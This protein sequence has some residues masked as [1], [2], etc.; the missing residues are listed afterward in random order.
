MAAARV[1][2]A[3]GYDPHLSAREMADSMRRADELGFEVGFFSET[4]EL[5]RD[6]VSTLAAMALSTERMT[7]GCTQIVRL[8][9]P[10]VMA[11]TA[12]TLDELSGGRMILSPGACT[13][14]HSRRYGLVPADP[15]TSL[16]EWIEIIRRLLRSE[17]FSYEGETIV[18][19]EA[20]LGWEPVRAE[21]PMWI[22][23]TSRTGLHLA[24]LLG[25]GVLLNAICSPEYT[26]N[27]L[28]IVRAAVEE[29]GREWADFEVAQLINCSVEDDS[30]TAIDTIR[31]EVASKFNPVQMPFIAGP[32]LRVGEP[33]IHESDLPIFTTAWESGGKDA[34]IRAIPDSYVTGMTASGTPD[35]VLARVDEYRRAG[36]RLP[37]LRPGAAHQTDR[38]LD[39]FA[40]SGV[41]EA[42]V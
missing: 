39:L 27:A 33:Y 8:R 14:S 12:A 11:Q 1:G 31:W 29:S 24:G 4:V 16:R 18:L 23:A 7:I 40:R 19:R 21:I 28:R 20:E 5:M 37:I 10:L 25:D 35:Q 3:T 42:A 30:A 41:V 26:V 38:L 36:V 34:L 6:S 9:S 13:P 2:F 32:K 15:A 22:P 17:R